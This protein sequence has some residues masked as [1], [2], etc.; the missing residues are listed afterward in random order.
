MSIVEKRFGVHVDVP[1]I[2][3]I[4]VGQHWGGAREIPEEEVYNWGAAA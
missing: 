3:D 2:A 1:I 4:K